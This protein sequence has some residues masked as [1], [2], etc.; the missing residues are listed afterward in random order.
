MLHALTH[1]FARIDMQHTRTTDIRNGPLLPFGGEE[2]DGLQ[3]VQC[4]SAN[5]P[6]G[7]PRVSLVSVKIAVLEC[8]GMP[9][10][11]AVVIQIR[12]TM[13]HVRV[14]VVPYHMLVIPTDGSQS[15]LGVRFGI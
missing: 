5:D 6:D 12:V 2:L 8:F 14:C 1:R 7:K 11:S 4:K 3:E 9:F 13:R 15:T 10:E